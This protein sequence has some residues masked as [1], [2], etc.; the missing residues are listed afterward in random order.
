M[1]IFLVQILFFVR[2]KKAKKNVLLLAKFLIFLAAIITLY[3]TVFHLLMVYEN[4]HYSWITGFYWTLT[5]MSTL[6]FGDI[7]FS[8]DL[9]LLFTL[10]VLLSG[11]ILMLIMLPFTFIQF[12]YAPWLEAQSQART[13][14]SLPKNTKN[15][16]ILTSYDPLSKNL[17]KKLTKHDY[18]YCFVTGDHQQAM[19][20][21]DAGYH[22]VLSEVDDPTTYINLRAE[23]AALIVA[24]S[25]DLM[26][27][28]ISFTVREVCEKTPIASS[29][30]KE[31]SLDILNF[32]ENTHVFPFMKML[33]INMA[34]KTLAFTEPHIIGRFETL[35][36]AEF[37][38]RDTPLIGQTLIHANLRQTLNI[39]VIGIWE[40]GK[41]LSPRA[42]VMLEKTNI[43]IVA[44]S[45]ESITKANKLLHP[46]TDSPLPSPT[47]LILGGG[48][49]GEAAAD[50]L[51][52]KQIPYIVIEK[53]KGV[54]KNDQFHV[55][56]D[57]ANI[58]VLKEAGINQASSVLITTHDDAMNIYL[59]FYCRQ[60]RPDIQIISR[61]TA[62]RTIPKL[63]RAGADLVDSSAV[64]GA[65]T[66]MSVLQPADVSFFSE[67]MNVFEV[68]TPEI[69]FGKN[70]T[71]LEVRKKTNCSLLAIKEGKS[72]ITNPNPEAVFPRGG[73]L[74]LAGSP[75]S[76]KLF[77]QEFIE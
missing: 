25:D 63:H 21:Y 5:V 45:E 34:E 26:N 3:S 59:A 2:N 23:Q 64:M 72:F 10:L 32:P 8:T 43:L 6:G 60:L 40:K 31:H 22:V 56:G 73:K 15:H 9:G 66:I 35:C 30:D 29:A 17:V 19:E 55:Y 58:A 52:E 77:R 44:G 50:F 36:V 42:D 16:V 33:G 68:P 54:F 38:V 70:L 69:F 24:T 27:T 48:R 51:K 75:E 49:V 41:I 76:E 11:V 14:H 13:P 61:A 39:T 20:I 1:K 53:R 71:E 37:P 7:T 12:F 57:A 28:N 74:I 46:Q 62:E 4:Q 65:S 18:Q 67:E 47:V